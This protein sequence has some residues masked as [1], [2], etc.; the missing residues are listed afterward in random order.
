MQ[1]LF[2]WRLS[3]RTLIVFDMMTLVFDAVPS[4]RDDAVVHLPHSTYQFQLFSP[5]IYIKNIINL[6][7][8]KD[9]II[10][11]TTGL[12]LIVWPNI[13]D[14]FDIIASFHTFRSRSVRPFRIVIRYLNRSHLGANI[15]FALTEE[16]RIVR[17]ILH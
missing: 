10:K 9:V 11:T 3:T 6:S 15:Y 7:T 2:T 12:Y 5:P 4:F 14:N 1:W 13:C 17:Q 16:K 8:F